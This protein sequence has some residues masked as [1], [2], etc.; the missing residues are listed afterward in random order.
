[1][2]PKKSTDFQK[3]TGMCPHGNFPSKCESCR[4]ENEDRTESLEK[5]HGFDMGLEQVS[6]Q[7][8]EFLKGS[9]K[10]QMLI[11]IAGKSGSGK[12]EFSRLLRKRLDSQNIDSTIIQSDDFY[13][14]ESD[15]TKKELYLEK[16]HSLIN[17]LQSGES[18]GKYETNPVIIIEGLQTVKDEVVGQKPDLR[19]F[20]ERDLGKRMEGRFVRDEKIGYR[21]IQDNLELLVDLVVNRPEVLQK[22]EGDMDMSGVDFVIENDYQEEDVPQLK[23]KGSELVFSK[24]DEIFA[25]ISVDDGQIEKLKKF[26]IV[27]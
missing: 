16:I 24:Q 17:K 7:V 1:M 5:I 2:N 25:R 21:S 27:D 4:Q 18:V 12:S 19:A 22:F 20:V 23:I 15:P 14:D 13:N 26:G 8:E 3:A 9:D 11:S 10:D 6:Q